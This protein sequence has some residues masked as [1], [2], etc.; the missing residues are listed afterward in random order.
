MDT[1]SIFETILNYC[2]SFF[3]IKDIFSFS[4]YDIDKLFTIINI[5]LALCLGIIT[6]FF[7]K[8]VF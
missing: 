6:S 3:S 8:K 1:L 4:R 7:I 5:I 2:L